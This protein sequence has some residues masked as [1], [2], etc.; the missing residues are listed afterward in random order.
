M[1]TVFHDVPHTAG[2]KTFDKNKLAGQVHSTL[3]V[4]HAIQLVDLASVPLRKLGVT[5]KQLIDTEKAQY[6][7]TRVGQGD[8][9][10]LPAR[11]RVVLG[12]QARRRGAC[13][14]SFR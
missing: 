11:P 4:Q 6:P 7:A 2:L 5:R 9:P 8:S 14:C 3:R 12:L 10:A 13:R 1:E